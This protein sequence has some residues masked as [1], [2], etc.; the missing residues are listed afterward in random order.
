MPALTTGG[1]PYAQPA[2][3]LVQWPDTSQALAEKIDTGI[4]DVR[5]SIVTGARDF[6]PAGGMAAGSIYTYAI[7]FP[8][9]FAS[10]PDVTAIYRPYDGAIAPGYQAP[11]AADALACHAFPVISGVT[12]SGFSLTLAAIVELTAPGSVQW[13]AVHRG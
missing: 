12:A 8:V 2:D 6:S 13:V 1:F 5:D 3:P 4:S 7:T 9:P 10:P 11:T